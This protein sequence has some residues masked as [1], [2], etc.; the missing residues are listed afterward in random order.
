M[1]QPDIHIPL[2]NR[3][4]FRLMR[5][6]LLVTITVGLLIGVGQILLDARAESRAMDEAVQELVDIVTR[7][8][9]E[10]AYNIDPTLAQTVVQGLT[11]NRGIYRA[12]I[13][14]PPGEVL[15]ESV[16]EV[17]R[18][19]SRVL[20]DTLFGQRRYYHAK[21]FAADEELPIGD[22][23][24]FLDTHPRGEAFL[25]RAG[26]LISSG[27]LRAAILTLVLLGLFMAL[28]TRPLARVVDG[29][30]HIDPNEPGSRRLAVPSGHHADEIGQTVHTTNRL[31]TAIEQA[32]DDRQKAEK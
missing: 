11:H 9:S 20:T 14:I 1:A 22:L 18:G 8:A 16:D 13:S 7:P 15:G 4:S 3:I 27:I 17:Q 29:L 10:A 21:L 28:I 31:L 24:V 30:A 32:S 23:H 2:G 19:L 12:S 6:C 26:L 25:A 5:L